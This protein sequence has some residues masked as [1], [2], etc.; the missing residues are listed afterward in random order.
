MGESAIEETAGSTKSES[1]LETLVAPVAMPKIGGEDVFI[2][3]PPKADEVASEE[4]KPDPFAAAAMANGSQEESIANLPEEMDKPS[5]FE[6]VTR[7]GRAAFGRM[8]ESATS[9]ETVSVPYPVKTNRETTIPAASEVIPEPVAVTPNLI[10]TAVAEAIEAESE[11]PQLIELEPVEEK[12]AKEDDLLDIPA[13]L[14]RQ[15]N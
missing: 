11:P 4:K 2:P 13:F 8:A 10:V 15:A 3:R 1:E 7:T 9:S 14:R 6:R 12:S 5:L